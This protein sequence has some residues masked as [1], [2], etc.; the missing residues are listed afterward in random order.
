MR[1][2]FIIVMLL[3]LLRLLVS[4]FRLLGLSTKLKSAKKSVQ[5]VMPNSAFPSSKQLEILNFFPP[6]V[7]S[8]L[9][10]DFSAIEVFSSCKSQ[11]GQDLLA[12]LVNFAANETTKSLKTDNFFVEFG[13]CD[14][15]AYSNTWILEKYFGWKG[16]LAEPGISFQSKITQNRPNSRISFDAVD[17]KTGMTKTFS[18]NLKMPS[19]SQ[20]SIDSVDGP[21]SNDSAKN[22]PVNT[23]SL[24]DLLIRFDA[25]SRIQF[26]SIDIE[27]NELPVLKTLD[28][29]KYSFELIVIEVANRKENQDTVGF[30][31]SKGYVY[32]K[33]LA[34]ASGADAWFIHESLNSGSLAALV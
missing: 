15:Q 12:L 26:L 6:N 14:G 10:I 19:L 7:I 9:F 13:A 22:Y 32:L 4:Y 17:V 8:R 3:S 25:P 20:L 11:V 5:K 28:F 23:I 16:I 31:E 1:R 2:I 33:Q 21:K 27:G 30:L 24:Q 34:Q 18:E 29:E